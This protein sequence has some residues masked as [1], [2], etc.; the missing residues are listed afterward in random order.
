MAKFFPRL[1]PLCSECTLRVLTS[2]TRPA[3]RKSYCIWQLGLLPLG[4][5]GVLRAQPQHNDTPA[6]G[7]AKLSSRHIGTKHPGI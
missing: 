1:P 4:G 3:A 6:R 7:R 5:S 2:T